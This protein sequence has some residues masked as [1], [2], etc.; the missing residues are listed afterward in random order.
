MMG[1]GESVSKLVLGVIVALLILIVVAYFVNWICAEQLAA[2]ATCILAGGVVVAFWQISQAKKSTNAQIAVGLF[3]KFRD[4]K[5]L[6][7][8]RETIY[9]ND[10]ETLGGFATGAIKRE[11]IGH[12]LDWLDILGI[13]VRKGIVDKDLAIMGF[14]GATAVRC[15]YKL[16][17]FIKEMQRIRGFYN[18]NYEDF[19]HSCVEIFYKRGN[20]RLHRGH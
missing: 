6:K 5:M 9:S 13:L 17:L 3:E 20:T 14:A 19:V 12:V 18:E 8:I 16:A 2:F 11:K 15:W 10:R 1:K 4:E 7:I